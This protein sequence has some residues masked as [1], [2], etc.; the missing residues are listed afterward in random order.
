M[1]FA[2]KTVDHAS[3]MSPQLGTADIFFPTDFSLLSKMVASTRPAGNGV[4][5][6]TPTNKDFMMRYAQ[7]ERTRTMTGYNPLLD[8]YTNM[9]MLLS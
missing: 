4:L 3:Y 2:E 6:E 7:L 9:R 8:D 5:I 1:N